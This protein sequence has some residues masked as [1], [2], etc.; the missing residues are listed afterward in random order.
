MVDLLH[1]LMTVTEQYKYGGSL[2]QQR[3]ETRDDEL[4]NNTQQHI[5][6]E[7]MKSELGQEQN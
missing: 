4:V 3:L 2:G 7:M 5:G 6:K 1:I